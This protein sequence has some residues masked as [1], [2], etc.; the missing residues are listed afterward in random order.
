M[1][2]GILGNKEFK[3]GSGKYFQFPGA[4]FLVGKE[5][6]HFGKKAYIIGG[7]TALKLVESTLESCLSDEGVAYI[8]EYYSGF[9]SMDKIHQL[10]DSIK[11]SCCEVVIAVG[12]GKVIDLAK[13]A[14]E[15]M[16]LP[17]ITVPTSAATCAAFAPLSV[18]YHN[19]GTYDH[20]IWHEREIDVVLV[21]SEILI[22]Q[23]SRLLASG[24]F[25]AMAKYIEIS[26]GKSELSLSN[27]TLP[28]LAASHM[29]KFIYSLLIQVSIPAVCKMQVNQNK[30]YINVSENILKKDIEYTIFL[31]IALT[32]IVSGITK[33]KGQTSVAHAFYNSIRTFFPKESSYY[34]HGEIVAVGTIAQLVFNGCENDIPLFK[35]YMSSL[36]M[37][38]S[39]HEMGI[40]LKSEILTLL[41]KDISEKRF[42]I[43]DDPH[44]ASLKKA[45][46]EVL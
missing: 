25:D 5:A 44:E 39:L 6:K 3:F 8:K 21:D 4:I 13:A 27:T 43:H 28:L 16:L 32:G 14:A 2:G 9:P 33:G 15:S 34:L 11:N 41:Y 46:E 22:K 7:N 29:A 45:L 23:P 10:E 19:D 26:N 24:I 17:I 30:D 38:C 12:G 31:N 37:P 35:K 1:F 20:C 42:M 18:I 36:N 40:D